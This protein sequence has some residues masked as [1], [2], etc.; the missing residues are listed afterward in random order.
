MTVKLKPDNHAYSDLIN[1]YE[2]FHDHYSEEDL[3]EVGRR[4]L[5]IVII[6]R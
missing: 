3:L 6:G 2:K 4:S 5:T 1:N